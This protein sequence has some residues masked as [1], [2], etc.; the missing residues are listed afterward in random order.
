MP[1]GFA[2]GNSPGSLQQK[3]PRYAAPPRGPPCRVLMLILIKVLRI[4][5][6]RWPLL[7]PLIGGSQNPVGNL[8]A[9]RVKRDLVSLLRVNERRHVRGPFRSWSGGPI[10]TASFDRDLELAGCPTLWCFHA[11][12]K[13]DMGNYAL[14]AR[15]LRI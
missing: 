10:A 13:R 9:V 5:I 1:L 7:C 4:T 6:A 8:G 11:P 12:P 14:V 2:L 15:L 3:W